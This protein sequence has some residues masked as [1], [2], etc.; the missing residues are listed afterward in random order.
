MPSLPGAG[1][2]K[3]REELLPNDSRVALSYGVTN[4]SLG[5]PGFNASS[6]PNPSLAELPKSSL[7]VA[8]HILE[9]LPLLVADSRFILK[10]E[11]P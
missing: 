7:P 4:E 10:K 5:I 6:V 3:I 2:F 1:C 9:S 8:A 11:V